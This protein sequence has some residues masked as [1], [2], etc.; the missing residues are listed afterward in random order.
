MK[1]IVIAVFAF[2]LAGCYG[3]LKVEFS[4]L[5]P[6]Y[7]AIS[8]ETRALTDQI[9]AAGTV[10]IEGM[11]DEE[12][13]RKPIEQQAA[14]E[15]LAAMTVDADAKYA[16]IVRLGKELSFISKDN[17]SAPELPEMNINELSGTFFAINRVD[18]K[19][20]KTAQD[21][22][23]CPYAEDSDGSLWS[24]LSNVS[25]VNS[26]VR[27][28]EWLLANQPELA[29][30][31]RSR[32]LLVRNLSDGLGLMR[33]RTQQS[34]EV[35][36]SYVRQLA[37]SAKAKVDAQ[38]AS[39][40]QAQQF[41]QYVN[42]VVSAGV[43]LSSLSVAGANQDANVRTQQPAAPVPAGTKTQTTED[44][45]SAT[46]GAA[47]TR[48][49]LPTVASAASQVG[50]QAKTSCDGSETT[51]ASCKELLKNVLDANV[52][53]TNVAVVTG[54]ISVKQIDNTLTPHPSIGSNLDNESEAYWVTTAPERFWAKKYDY[55]KGSGKFG[56]VN[57]AIRYD[58]NSDPDSQLGHVSVKG[59]TFD[60]SQVARVAS[61]TVVQSLLLAAQ[62]EGVPISS[63]ASSSANPND[64]AASALISASTDMGQRKQEMLAL[65]AENQDSRRAMI[66]VAMSAIGQ[67]DNLSDGDKH[68]TA[69]ALVKAA[70]DANAERIAPTPATSGQ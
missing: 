55:A 47:S 22:K 3:S 60:P 30:L 67:H 19:I 18:A 35:A 20:A 50:A 69:A 17:S 66:A 16:A 61:K 28:E 64:V 36:A 44:A 23:S 11:K 2:S 62:I 56:D 49:S 1:R 15:V 7:V 4:V 31:A 25:S 33:A 8:T 54:L 58:P 40:A 37:D 39:Q 13:L 43:G 21:G 53:L 12:T 51:F 52:S 57:I 38:K 46:V 6:E 68:D 34:L 9:I 26:R 48:A 32:L 41:Q 42:G 65:D 10:P 70:F 63:G 24:G 27:C 29:S 14:E 5:D 59:L 45:Q